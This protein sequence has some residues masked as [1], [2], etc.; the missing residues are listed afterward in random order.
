MWASVLILV[1]LLILIFAFLVYA[2]ANIASGVYL[3]AECRI[4]HQGNPENAEKLLA[5]T[6]D[7][8][9][10][11]ATTP[12][13]LEILKKRGIKAVFFCTGKNLESNRE[14]AQMI[15]A[16]GHLLGNHTYSHSF[17]FPFYSSK[18]MKAEIAHCQQIISE[19]APA[20][21]QKLFRPP[22]GV[23]NPNLRKALRGSDFRVIGW[24]IRSLDT[25]K[26]SADAIFKRV[27]KRLRPGGII[28]FHDTLPQTADALEKFIN[29][30][31]QAG[32]E[33][34]QF[35]PQTL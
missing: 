31:K 6:F 10:D 5:L 30:S 15:A 12:K 1:L 25:V 18:R 26:A 22:F 21:S 24:N 33:F 29:H 34:I 13:I 11:E 14:L 19:I 8:G 7:D 20:Q 28:L 32:Y 2:S 4:T 23:T 16:E 35:P 9:P 3:K 27:S 17:W